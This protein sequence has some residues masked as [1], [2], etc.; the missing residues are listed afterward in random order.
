MSHS[1]ALIVVLAASNLLLLV[2]L[3]GCNRTEEPPASPPNVIVITLD[4]MRADHMSVYGYHRLTSPQVTDLAARATFYTRAMAS[5]PWTIPTHASLFTGMDPFQHGARTLKTTSRVHN[6]NPLDGS[7]LT[8]AEALLNEGYATGAFVS[9]DGMLGTRWQLDQG[10][11]RYHIERVI[12]EELNVRVFAWLDSVA[13]QQKPFFLFI[14]YMDTHKVYNTKPRPG[15]LDEPAVRDSGQLLEALYAAVMPGDRPVPADLAQKVID[16]Y[17]TAVANVDEQVGVL[18]DTLERLG[19]YDGTVIVVTSD[20]GEFFG[21]HHLV[22]HSK[23]V[24]QEVLWV[25]LV[26]KGA[27]QSDGRRDHTVI[28][29]SDL[30]RMI[31][32]EFPEEFAARYRERFPN[33]PG[34]HP[35]L[36]ENYYTRAK[37]LFHPVWGK[38]FNRVRTAVYEWPYKYIHSSDGN[39][40]LYHLELDEKESVNLIGNNPEA[41]NRMY[42]ALRLFLKSRPRFGE[43]DR[44]PTLSDEEIKKLKSLG[45]IGN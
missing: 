6:I 32:S 25:P 10:F 44:R 31:L 41:G 1:Q 12:A 35:V 13:A 4:T 2:S 30:P 7:H 5:A 42:D 38:R 19:L 11:E 8:L 17:D 43:A 21:E 15:L 22:T 26:I 3:Q 20:H 40:E 14:N 27:R 23:D 18:V 45:Y 9:N 24:Y 36:S 33:E 34:N 29:S 28:S 16:Q 37:D 39:S